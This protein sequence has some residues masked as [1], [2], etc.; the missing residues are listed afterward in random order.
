MAVFFKIEWRTTCRWGGRKETCQFNP[1]VSVIHP[2]F[3][4]SFETYCTETDAMEQSSRGQTNAL[5]LRTKNVYSKKEIPIESGGICWYSKCVVRRIWNLV[6]SICCWTLVD[7]HFYISSFFH[8][9]H[10]RFP[11]T[12]LDASHSG[13]RLCSSHESH[14]FNPKHQK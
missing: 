8:L 7:V 10:L 9:N 4:E 12:Q 1:K 13:S 3:V 5:M 14:F 2:A 11:N 6:K